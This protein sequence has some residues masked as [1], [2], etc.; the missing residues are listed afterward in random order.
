MWYKES[1]SHRVTQI[2]QS[3]TDLL[4]VRNPPQSDYL[5]VFPASTQKSTIPILATCKKGRVT[6]SSLFK[7]SILILKNK[8]KKNNNKKKTLGFLKLLIFQYDTKTT[9]IIPVLI[10]H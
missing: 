8:T 9:E 2:S 5:Q 6:K 4:P 3:D 10:L 1:V 7:L